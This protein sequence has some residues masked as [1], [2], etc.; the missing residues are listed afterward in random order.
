[1]HSL[2]NLIEEMTYLRLWCVFG[3]STQQCWLMQGEGTNSLFSVD[4]FC[5]RDSVWIPAG[6]SALKIAGL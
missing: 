5:R 1:M 6:I 2:K 4:H 3:W